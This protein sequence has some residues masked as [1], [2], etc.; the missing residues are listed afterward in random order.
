MPHN[1]GRVSR[2]LRTDSLR[3]VIRANLVIL[4]KLAVRAKRKIGLPKKP[5]LSTF[6]RAR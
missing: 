3:L 1:Q 5:D 6:V 4:A 2:P